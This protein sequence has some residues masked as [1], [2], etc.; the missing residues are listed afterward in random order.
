M[1][2]HFFQ[3]LKN[4]KEGNCGLSY[5][6]FWKINGLEMLYMFF[7]Q[8]QQPT[9]THRPPHLPLTGSTW[10]L[11]SPTSDAPSDN[12]WACPHVGCEG[13]TGC[14]H[15]IWHQAQSCFLEISGNQVCQI[16][17]ETSRS[18]VESFTIYKPSFLMIY[19]KGLLD[20]KCQCEHL[21][22]HS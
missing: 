1:L 11:L 3:P 15:H 21:H 12:E 8:P 4:K 16:L 2:I 18:A 22:S 20:R 14:I 19:S 5:S 13:Y 17:H 7:P 9:S 6:I 10:D